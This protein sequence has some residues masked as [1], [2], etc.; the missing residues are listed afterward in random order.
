[1]MKGT[2]TN[3][4]LDFYVYGGSNESQNLFAGDKVYRSSAS[5]PWKYD[6][7]KYW[8]K[9]RTYKFAAISPGAGANLSA[10]FGYSDGHMELT[11][12][13][14]NATANQYDLVYGEATKTTFGGFKQCE[15]RC[16]QPWSY[17]FQNTYP[18]REK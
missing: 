10:N 4:L 3:K 13:V 1:M 12:T 18:V 17:P 7:T 2:V 8:F 5:D 16:I 15:Y 11:A 14:D 6:N 9:N